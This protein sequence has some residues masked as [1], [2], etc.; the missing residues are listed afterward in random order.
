M[1][2][3]KMLRL[4]HRQK[5]GLFLIA[6]VLVSLYIVTGG[7]CVD[8]IKASSGI[9]IKAY[10]IT[11]DGSFHELNEWKSF[12]HKQTITDTSGNPLVGIALCPYLTFSKTN[13]GTESDVDIVY[14][15]AYSTMNSD[16]MWQV[17]VERPNNDMDPSGWMGQDE[18]NY[19]TY[20]GERYFWRKYHPDQTEFWLEDPAVKYSALCPAGFKVNNFSPFVMVFDE[21]FFN[22]VC[23]YNE[24]FWVSQLRLV[25]NA[26]T[27]VR[28]TINVSVRRNGVI[29]KVAVGTATFDIIYTTGSTPDTGNYDISVD[30][31]DWGIDNPTPPPTNPPPNNGI[32]TNLTLS[33]SSSSVNVGETVIVTAT[34]KN[35][36]TGAVLSNKRVDIIDVDSGGTIKSGYTNTN[37]KV[38][39]NVTESSAVTRRFV[40]YFWG[41]SGYNGSESNTISVTWSGSGGGG[42]SGYGVAVNGYRI[43]LD[44]NGY[45]VEVMVGDMPLIKVA[46][47]DDNGNLLEGRIDVSYGTTHISKYVSSDDGYCITLPSS[48]AP[49]HIGDTK[50]VT[51]K[52]MGSSKSISIRF[53]GAQTIATPPFPDWCE[54]PPEELDQV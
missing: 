14:K 52:L 8:K 41:D 19:T 2:I 35:S 33:S 39:V 5:M 49:D 22:S 12:F 38:S 48:W 7:S 34:L 45:Y 53:I 51:I 3:D 36:N 32:P 15:V 13:I 9:N 21:S 23:S 47:Y 26:R 20:N 30:F 1:P 6:L 54:D 29:E 40:A 4:T 46:P 44:N 24:A 18:Y 17:R 31:K 27:S 16:D 42:K 37:G 43:R 11:R 10:G 28:F 25:E 50:N